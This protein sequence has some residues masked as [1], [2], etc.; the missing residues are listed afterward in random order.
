MIMLF[1]RKAAI[2]RQIHEA[3]NPAEIRSVLDECRENGWLKEGILR[4]LRL[5][6]PD[7]AGIDLT[8]ADLKDASL[9]DANLEQ[10]TLTGANLRDVDL[11]GAKLRGANLQGAD[12][13][14]TILEDADL[15]GANVL[16][17]QLVRAAA[18]DGATMPNG[19]RYDGRYSLSL[20]LDTAESEHVY[21]DQP[22][23]LAEWYGIPIEIYEAGQD[24]AAS[25]LSDLR[26]EAEY[27]LAGPPSDW[28]EQMRAEGRLIDGTLRNA[29]LRHEVLSM[30][31]LHDAVLVGTL[32][33]EV[34]A[35]HTDFLGAKLS[36]VNFTEADLHASRFTH[37]DL[38]GATLYGADMSDAILEEADLTDADLYGTILDGANLKGAKI[39]DVEL[40]QSDSMAGATM[41]DGTLYDGRYN[42]IGD[43]MNAEEQGIDIK[44]EHE[45]SHWYNVA[46][47]DYR[48]GQ[49]WAKMNLSRLRPDD[50]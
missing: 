21:P 30:S 13:T 25:N 11:S 43:L 7:L 31:D 27:L 10:A 37:A 33:D 39:T 24:W 48:V 4:K 28:A 36:G 49:Q 6:Q 32:M 44:S 8:G 2:F 29:D 26:V 20:D 19:T 45:F 47:E 14:G 40:V 38:H 15:T 22:E 3:W 46:V 35:H 50:Q 12:L 9:P 23:R 34:E 42:L 16:P 1:G 41:P 5:N 18:L 17:A